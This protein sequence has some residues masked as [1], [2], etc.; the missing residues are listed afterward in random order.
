MYRPRRMCDECAG[1]ST[2]CGT[3]KRTD[4]DEIDVCY[5]IYVYEFSKP[6]DIQI[7]KQRDKYASPFNTVWDKDLTCVN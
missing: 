4:A 2:Q 1:P 5:A 7:S 6:L 3:Q